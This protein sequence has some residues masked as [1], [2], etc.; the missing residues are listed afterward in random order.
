MRTLASKQTKMLS[1]EL[2]TLLESIHTF[3]IDKTCGKVKKEEV[4]KDNII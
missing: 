1:K 2:P 3:R 4:I